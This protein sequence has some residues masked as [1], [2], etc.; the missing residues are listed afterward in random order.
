M[1]GGSNLGSHIVAEMIE[2]GSV[3]VEIGVWRGDTTARFLER[4]GH[5]HLV[6]PWDL[7]QY[8]TREFRQFLESYRHIVGSTDPEDF[9]QHYCDVEASVRSR[10]ALHPVTFHKMTSREFFD[11]F[12]EKVDWVYI[13]GLH[14]YLN[15]LADLYGARNILKPGG[16][17]YGDDYGNKP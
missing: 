13:D 8:R 12:T 14:D 10:F 16:M 1:M 4:A 9:R 11:T 15:V 6:D 17:I 3:G 2:P 7:E 5:V